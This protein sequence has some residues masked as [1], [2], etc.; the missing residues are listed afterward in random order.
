MSDYIAV[1]SIK[2]RILLTRFYKV[3]NQIFCP[4]QVIILC[5]INMCRMLDYLI[6]IFY[7]IMLMTKR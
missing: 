4:N 5:V 2:S 3:P 7:G 1:V 6:N